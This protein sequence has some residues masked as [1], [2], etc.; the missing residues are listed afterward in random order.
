MR[1]ITE[2]QLNKIIT[3]STIKVLKEYS[4]NEGVAGAIGAGLGWL[5][6]KARNGVNNFSQN[7]QQQYNG[8]TQQQQGTVQTGTPT[9]EQ[10]AQYLQNL[11]MRISNLESNMTNASNNAQQSATATA[12]PARKRTKKSTTTNQQPPTAPT[13]QAKTT[14]Q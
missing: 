7:F 1:Y 13:T 14:Q 3:E 9:I 10:L 2:K 12:N 11:N 5:A 4:E 6:N 8:N